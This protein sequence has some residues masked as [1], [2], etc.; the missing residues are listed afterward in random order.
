[1]KDAGQAEIHCKY[2][3]MNKFKM[4]QKKIPNY[5]IRSMA[6]QA[7]M[8]NKFYHGCKNSVSRVQ[9]HESEISS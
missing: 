7:K 8:S 9:N 4:E 3:P 2:Y 6:F 1:M 5:L